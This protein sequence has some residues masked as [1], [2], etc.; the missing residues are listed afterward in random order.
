MQEAPSHNEDE[1]SEGGVDD[2]IDEDPPQVE[3]KI[4]LKPLED[5]SPLENKVPVEDKRP[6][7]EEPPRDDWAA[8]VV[9]SFLKWY[10]E[11]Q[12][13]SPTGSSLKTPSP[14][15]QY[16]PVDGATPPVV[17]EPLHKR[18][19]TADMKLTRQLERLG[20]DKE[21][22]QGIK[23]QRDEQKQRKEEAK[24][25]KAKDKAE[26]ERNRKEKN[27]TEE[28]GVKDGE[29][30]KREGPMTQALNAFLATKKAEG[31]TYHVIL[32]LW[33]VSPERKAVMDNLSAS[34]IKRRRY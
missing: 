20:L 27:A 23:E 22:I 3:D 6:L 28:S 5:K 8:S 33:K 21:A 1:E 9:E 32:K 2:E 30:R 4:P 13:G 31:Y 14:R 15:T 19:L 18:L 7:N 29:K 11:G 10:Q 24:L 12:S 34:E 25:Q 16:F 17:A 26:K